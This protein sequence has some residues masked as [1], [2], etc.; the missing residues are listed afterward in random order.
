MFGYVIP[1]KPELKIKDYQVFK[2]Y[3]CGLCKKINHA[4]SFFSRA[5]LNYDCAF[6]YLLF[7][8]M[9]PHTPET[10]KEGCLFNPFSK[11]QVVYSPESDYAAGLNML[12]TYYKFADNAVD[13]KDIL[14]YI[15]KW[16]F[17]GVYKRSV[18]KHTQIAQDIHQRLQN[19]S[20]LEKSKETSLDKT[21]NEFASV[22]ACIFEHAPFDWLHEDQREILHDLGYNLGRFIYLLDAYDDLEKDIQ[23]NRYNP[24]L[25][26]FNYTGDITEFKKSIRK[27]M[28]FNLY[29]SLSQTAKCYDALLIDK[30]R[31]LLDNIIYIGLKSKTSD[32]LEGRK[33]DGSL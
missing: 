26:R 10:K 31:D 24:L 23:R 11:K 7:S 4:Y 6:L 30:N 19:L 21:A 15:L 14:C 2:G 13:D 9:S 33:R 22:N 18:K 5:Y 25:L 16:L 29:Y 28:E 3:Y 17:T 20:Q 12:L 1:F 8:S 27:D 32:V